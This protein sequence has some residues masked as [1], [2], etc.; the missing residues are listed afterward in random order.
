[1]STSWHF[2]S[3]TQED[4]ESSFNWRVVPGAWMLPF[5]FLCSFS[6]KRYKLPVWRQQNVC[7]SQWNQ[8]FYGTV[9]TFNSHYFL[10]PRWTWSPPLPSSPRARYSWSY[11]LENLAKKKIFFSLLEEMM[12]DNMTSS[13]REEVNRNPSKCSY[14]LLKFWGLMNHLWA[15]WLLIKSLSNVSCSPTELVAFINSVYFTDLLAVWTLSRIPTLA[16]V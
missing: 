1:M 15:R 8:S 3:S 13:F 7:G 4:L 2:I 10:V 16:V 6:G 12:I 9:P 5:I 11:I 14:A